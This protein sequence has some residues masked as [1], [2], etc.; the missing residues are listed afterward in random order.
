MH[1][2]SFHSLAAM[3]SLHFGV[4]PAALR[5]YARM[6]CVSPIH[7]PPGLLSAPNTTFATL[8]GGCGM[9]CHWSVANSVDTVSTGPGQVTTAHCQQQ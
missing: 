5:M 3:P 9:P 2:C 8:K 1:L 7:A 4:Y 6:F